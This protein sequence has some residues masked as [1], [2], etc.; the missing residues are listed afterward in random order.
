MIEQMMSAVERRHK[1]FWLLSRGLFTINIAFIAYFRTRI[2]LTE[3]V[4][5]AIKVQTHKEHVERGIVHFIVTN[6]V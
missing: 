4:F 6:G 1:V 5:N 3:K 2:M